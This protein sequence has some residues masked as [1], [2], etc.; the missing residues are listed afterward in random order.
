MTATSD[1]TDF[2]AAWNALDRTDRLRLRRL[3]RMGRPIDDPHLASI[4][5]A[6]ARFQCARPWM[7]FFWL[8]FIPGVLIALV[9]VA[10][11]HP[12]LIGVV[13]ALGAQAVWAWF[14]LRRVARTSVALVGA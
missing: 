10:G 2:S 8:W 14:S 3:A 11:I 4:A 6:Y 5:H 13:L 7:R 12:V 9:A 1:T